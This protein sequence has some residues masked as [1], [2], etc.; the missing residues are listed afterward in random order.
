M[1]WN[2]NSYMLNEL[3]QKIAQWTQSPDDFRL[4]ERISF[5]QKTAQW[6]RPLFDPV[7]GMKLKW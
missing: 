3:Q 1:L 7:G 5:T 6:P 2:V 4:L